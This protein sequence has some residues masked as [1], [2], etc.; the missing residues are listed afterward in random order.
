MSRI[1]ASAS[2]DVIEA[3][4]SVWQTLDSLRGGDSHVIDLRGKRLIG[5]GDALNATDTATRRQADAASGSGGFVDRLKTLTVKLF[6]RVLGTMYLPA[7]DDAGI[8]FVK[9][10]GSL[11][12]DDGLSYRYTNRALRLADDGALRWHHLVWLKAGGTA[13]VSSIFIISGEDDNAT[14]PL[15][16][17]ALGLD[18]AGH[19]ALVPNG[20]N[21]E[22]RVGG[23]SG[24]LTELSAKKFNP[25]SP[26]TY[27]ISNATTTRSYDA[28]TVDLPTLA[29]TVGTL[30][31]DV[32]TAGLVL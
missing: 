15:L 28:T 18:S 13:N 26:Q 8:V 19:P 21:L 1:P 16:R 7:L 9:S 6:L 11:A 23:G 32:R 5:V 25:D 10:D 22:I 27:T 3:F 30:V 17:V 12:T 20:A 24:A 29:K 2:P 31:Q 4:R 14:A